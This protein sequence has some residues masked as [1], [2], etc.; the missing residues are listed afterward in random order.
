MLGNSPIS[1]IL[2]NRNIE[3]KEKLNVI[4]FL[5][6][7]GAASVYDVL[8][9]EKYENRRI[10]RYLQ[11]VLVLGK[12]EKERML[13]R[14]VKS[15]K[16]DKKEEYSDCTPLAGSMDFSLFREIDEISKKSTEL[17]GSLQC[18]FFR[19]ERKRSPSFGELTKKIEVKKSLKQKTN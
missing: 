15:V 17:D 8:A 5:V 12:S 7:S 1:A 10:G 14:I 4:K 18:T 9:R 16:K 19:H 11:R 6:N 2:V 3:A 13:E